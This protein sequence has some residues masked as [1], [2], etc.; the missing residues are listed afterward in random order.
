MT[1]QTTFSGEIIIASL[2]I[3]L[4]F[5]LNDYAGNNRFDVIV[6]QSKTITCKVINNSNAETLIWYRGSQQVDIKAENSVNSSTI[7][8][9]GVTPEDH[10]VSFT[11]LLKR[12]TTMKWSGQLNVTFEPILSGDKQIFAEEGKNVQIICGYKA[13]P[14]VTMS[15]RQNGSIVAY[16]SR[17]EQL[18]TS[19]AWTLSITKAT[20]ADTANYTCVAVT[21]NGT[22]YKLTVELLIGDRIPG[23][24]VEAIGGAVVVGTLIILFGLFAR[25]KTIF[26]HCMKSRNN[27]AM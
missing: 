15:W 1:R 14:P 13:N 16:P 18:M 12:D 3:D 25:R 4:S 11:C 6:N 17:F 7:C 5:M 23:L 9:P 8:L 19:N 10:G 20:K 2:Y 24:P 22:E 26:K 27:T 21:P